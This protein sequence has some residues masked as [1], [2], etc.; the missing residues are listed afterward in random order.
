MRFFVFVIITVKKITYYLLL[1]IHRTWEQCITRACS[2]DRASRFRYRTII[3]DPLGRPAFKSPGGD[4][5]INYNCPPTVILYTYIDKDGFNI[6]PK[7]IIHRT[8]IALSYRST[9]TTL[10][11][12]TNIYIYIYP[13]IALPQ[14]VAR[15]NDR[16][17]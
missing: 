4:L 6:N 9:I 7:S 15:F 1:N 3:I 5:R 12:Y 13:N 16:R 2:S 10:Y 11:T 17:E 14:P 8:G